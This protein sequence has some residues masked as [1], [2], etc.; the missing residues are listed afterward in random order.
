MNDASDL[1]RT[2]SLAR[3]ADLRYGA[4]GDHSWQTAS[5]IAGEHGQTEAFFCLETPVQ[6]TAPIAHSVS[7]L[8]LKVRIDLLFP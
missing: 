5:A 8:E 4:P 3:G 6:T 7:S 2:G 1:S